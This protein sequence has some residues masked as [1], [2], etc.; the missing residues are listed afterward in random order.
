MQLNW[1]L[2]LWMRYYD[3]GSKQESMQIKTCQFSKPPEVPGAGISWQ[4]NV[5]YFL[6][7]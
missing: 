6:G 1:N 4:G 7:C 2:Y 3:P 5:H